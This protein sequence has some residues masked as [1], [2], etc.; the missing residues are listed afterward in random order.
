MKVIIIGGGFGGL[1][2]AKELAGSDIQVIII[3]RTN[4]HLFQPLLYQVATAALSPGDIA[5][6]IRTV[7]S[8]KKNIEVI[9]G[10]VVSI[11][12]SNKKVIIDSGE[13]Y[14]F[15]YLIVATGSSHSYFG[16]DQWE[17]FAPGLKTLSDGLKI[18]EKLLIS[19]EK[20]EKLYGSPEADKYLTFVVIGGGPTGVELAG[21][22]SE[23]IKRNVT[24]DFRHIDASKIKIILVEGLK[25]ILNVYPEVLSQKAKED[26]VKMGVVVMLE[27]RVTGINENGVQIGDDFIESKNVLWAAGNAAS[28]LLKKLDVPLDKAGRVLVN[29]DL[30]IPGSPNIFVI[31]DAATLKD[32][33][34]EF[35][36]GIAPVAIQMGKHAAKV[37]KSDNPEKRKFHYFDKGTMATIGRAK[38]VAKIRNLNFSGFLA[39]LMWTFIHIFFLIGF[40]NRLR[41]MAEWVWFYFT[42]R[43][44]IRLITDRFDKK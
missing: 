44:G 29:D 5:V 32:K 34:G 14:L 13:E 40:R 4:H 31:G 42:F 3:D 15:D 18:R 17:V 8:K 24:K 22:L 28:P 10:D 37:I 39:W 6:P 35:L 16:K 43:P 19:L 21:A 33:Y 12:K 26:L 1:N 20:A 38:A 7:F 9:L 11:D 23:I 2:A 41:V 36:P 27:K 25:R 30:T